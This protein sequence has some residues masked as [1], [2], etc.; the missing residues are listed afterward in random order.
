MLAVL[1]TR[2]P[3]H[4]VGLVA[5]TSP[6]QLS[7]HVSK[8]QP[9]RSIQ[10]HSWMSCA[11]ARAFAKSSLLGSSLKSFNALPAILVTELRGIQK[12]PTCLQ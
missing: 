9:Y 6:E 7:A 5:H 10:A 2:L 3:R 1:S 12:C 8:V 4:H 11:A